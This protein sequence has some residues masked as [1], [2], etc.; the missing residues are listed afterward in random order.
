M[1]GDRLGK[2]ARA[3]IPQQHDLDRVVREFKENNYRFGGK[4]P[5]LLVEPSDNIGGGAPGDGTDVM[6]ALLKYDI[7]GAGV[8]IADAELVKA[9]ADV[10][11][12]G[13]DHFAH[14]R[15]RQPADLGP[16]TLE[17]ELVSRSDGVFE[18]EDKKSHL[19]GSLARSSAWDPAPWCGIAA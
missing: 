10:P 9:L 4:G 12:W 3:G 2:C 14:R 16:V 17:V 19:V 8:V 1:G 18:L 15:Q 7:P 6:R 5:V 11:I 13:Q